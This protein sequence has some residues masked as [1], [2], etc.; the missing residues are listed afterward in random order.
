MWAALQSVLL[1]ASVVTAYFT[2]R[3]A[4][5]ARRE[6]AGQFAEQRESDRRRLRAENEKARQSDREARLREV[7]E[8]IADYEDLRTLAMSG[9]QGAL[10][11]A[12]PRKLRLQT[13]IIATG[14]DLPA[15]QKYL[16][17][18][19]PFAYLA[20]LQPALDELHESLRI[21]AT[22]SLIPFEGEEG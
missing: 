14:R 3:E 9:D 8:R 10:M 19:N 7:V 12:G 6:D 5:S 21:H 20:F 11:R 1:L 16:A 15:T 4:R 18:S 22:V 17:A 2:V 13:A